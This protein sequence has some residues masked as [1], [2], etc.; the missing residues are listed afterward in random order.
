MIKCVLV[1]ETWVRMR[2]VVVGLFVEARYS[3]QELVH[4]MVQGANVA[5]GKQCGH[6]GQCPEG[7]G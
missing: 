6:G 7:P 1:R 4:L 2:K 3:N 5:D